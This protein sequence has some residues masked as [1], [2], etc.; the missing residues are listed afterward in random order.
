MNLDQEIPKNVFVRLCIALHYETVAY[1]VRLSRTI[2]NR[3]N[4][5]SY[6]SSKSDIELFGIPYWWKLPYIFT[7]LLSKFCLWE[8]IFRPVLYGV[9][10]R[11]TC[12]LL[13]IILAD[14]KS[15]KNHI[16]FGTWK[17]FRTFC[18]S[19]LVRHRFWQT[20]KARGYFDAVPGVSLLIW[21]TGMLF[22]HDHQ[23]QA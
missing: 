14:C 20:L 5:C 16:D 21:R 23:E 19:S 11:G 4:E 1:I 2:V 7:D 8:S 3:K 22:G 10:N 12:P 9:P 6:W 13:M 17:G 15:V 18:P